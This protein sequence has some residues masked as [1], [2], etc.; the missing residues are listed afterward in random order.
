MASG[1]QRAGLFCLG[2]RPP[3]WYKSARL[4]AAGS[5]GEKSPALQRP[6]LATC[7]PRTALDSP[8]PASAGSAGSRRTLPS[9]H[10]NATP[11]P[12]P[13]S[14]LRTGLEPQMGSQ[15]PRPGP[16]WPSKFLPGYPRWFR[17]AHRA[18]GFDATGAREIS[19]DLLGRFPAA[20]RFSGV[21][22]ARDY[23]LGIW[24]GQSFPD[25]KPGGGGEKVSGWLPG[26]PRGRPPPTHPQPPGADG[27]RGS[28]C[29]CLEEK[30]KYISELVKLLRPSRE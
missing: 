2:L 5:Q 16:S 6:L 8:L 19:G 4:G 27:S 14:V 9:L 1:R 7:R 3:V 21:G 17:E 12:R 30:P 13:C 25:L 29:V 15:H 28:G 11:H 24:V 26:E 23:R 22:S 20:S 10:P 18:G